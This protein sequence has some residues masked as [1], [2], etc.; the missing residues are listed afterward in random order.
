M[1]KFLDSAGLTYLW[2]KIAAAFQPSISAS[3][4]LK[5]DGSGGVSAATAGT[6]YQAPLPSQSGNS[7]K[8]LT[9]DGS[10]MSWATISAGTSDIFWITVTADTSGNTTTYSADKTF[11]QIEAAITAD[12]IIIVKYDGYFYQLSTSTNYYHRFICSSYYDAAIQSS[13]LINPPFGYIRTLEV[14][15]SDNWTYY[16]NEQ[17]DIFIVKAYDTLHSEIKEAYNAGKMIFC[18]DPTAEV[19][20]A[21]CN[22][23][24]PLA[25][26]KANANGSEEFIFSSV[27]KHIHGQGDPDFEIHSIIVD[28]N[29]TWTVSDDIIATIPSAPDGE[30]WYRAP[31]NMG[32]INNIIHDG[33]YFVAGTSTGVWYSS[34]GLNWIQT[35]FHENCSIAYGGGKYVACIITGE[36]DFDFVGALR[37][38]YTTDLTVAG[39]FSTIT[40][41]YADDGSNE[42]WTDITF[43]G[44]YFIAETNYGLYATAISSNLSSD[45]WVEVDSG[46][47]GECAIFASSSSA[48]TIAI[49]ELTATIYVTTTTNGGAS[50]TR[51]SPSFSGWTSPMALTYG[52]A[53]GFIAIMMDGNS[54]QSDA[55]FQSSDGSSWTKL[56][57][58]LPY[59]GTYNLFYDDYDDKYF[60]ISSSEEKIWTSTNGTTWTELSNPVSDE[61]VWSSF[62]KGEAKAAIGNNTIYLCGNAY[63]S[64]ITGNTP[65]VA[66]INYVQDAIQ[67]IRPVPRKQVVRI[68]TANWDSSTLECTASIVGITDSSI[69][70]VSPH[71]NS[72]DL[73]AEGGVYCSSQYTDRLVFACKKIPSNT[74][75]MLVSW[76]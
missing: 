3:G 35:N 27:N 19:H 7:G 36:Y 47:F 33:T 1:A 40:N 56:S 51:T 64:K 59:G 68:R 43:C 58:T 54:G 23:Y 50:W 32:T 62:K 28:S 61:S 48:K 25:R 63:S 12:R 16:M 57:Q 20:D 5:G 11:A 55:L 41:V 26:Y 10:A 13:Q 24:V 38:F 39:W 52:S 34:D 66:T 17:A 53:G 4:I 31:Y 67:T 8:F 21:N 75:T 46:L 65:D 73:A 2:G 9:T 44:S 45:G 29:D 30:K 42:Y 14:D 18:I 37:I 15:D 76:W 71:P 74:V 60:I 70:Y 49:S 72:I 22:I 69:V 6:D